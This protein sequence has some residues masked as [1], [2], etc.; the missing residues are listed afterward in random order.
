MESFIR[1]F[2]NEI[3]CLLAPVL[4]IFLTKYIVGEYIMDYVLLSK[5]DTTIELSYI[6]L[7]TSGITNHIFDNPQMG[8]PLVADQNYWPWRNIGIGFYYFIISIFEKD[9]LEIYR[10]FYYSLFPVASLT[11]FICLRYFLNLPNLISLGVS[12]IYAFM[13][14]MYSHNAQHPTVLVGVLC[15]PLVLGSIFY[16]NFKDFRN[17]SFTR[18]IKSKLS[19]IIALIF[20]VSVTLS[21][22][23]AFYSLVILIFLL[24]LQMI[25]SNKDYNRI[26]LILFI[27]GINLLAIFFNIY[28]HLLFK[29]DSHFTFNYMARNFIHT[30]LYSVSIADFFI[31]VKNHIIDSFNFSSQLY[32]QGTLIKDFFNISYLGIFGISSLIFSIFCFFRRAGKENNFWIKIAFIGSLITFLILMFVRGGLMTTFYLYSDLFVLGSNYRITPWILCLSLMSGGLI[33]SHLYKTINQNKFLIKELTKPYIKGISILLFLLIVSFSL[34]DFRG[35]KPVFNK[36]DIP[37]RGSIY[38]EEKAFFDKLEKLITENDMILQ[39]P[40]VCFQETKNILGT[41]Y[42]NT[43][44]YLLIDKKVKF[45]AMS[46]REGTACNINSQLSSM[47]SDTSEMIKY[48]TYFGYT[49]LMIEKRGFIDEGK[50]IKKNILENFGLEP[51]IDSAYLYFDIRGL[52]KEF[53]NIKII[54]KESDP[55]STILINKKSNLIFKEIKKINQ[56]FPSPCMVDNY[57]SMTVNSNESEKITI[58]NTNCE[59][60]K[61]YNN[62]FFYFSDDTIF[63]APGVNMSNGLI[64]LNELFNGDVLSLSIGVPIEPGI[65]K[66]F[67]NDNNGLI[68]DIKSLSLS[69]SHWGRG[70]ISDNKFN[71]TIENKIN[72]TRLKPLTIIIRKNSSEKNITIRSITIRKVLKENK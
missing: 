22:F 48:A 65:Y 64:Y 63:P 27:V 13:P 58:T 42:L 70:F 35:N 21:L 24:I 46:M 14:F 52:K 66:V 62:S 19:I 44:S 57:S 36:K 68:E 10:I 60:T 45:S 56:I 72:A 69:I 18:L 8:A 3:F 29:S 16:I 59:A 71:F 40:F 61:M 7:Y 5:Y 34:I 37:V 15:V 32:S 53:S 33:L 51:L 28:P 38:D 43:W 6:K 9:I 23:S 12:S 50:A 41:T 54:P 2:S 1:K 49:G 26:K 25:I 39:I 31:P 11:M 55:L 17:V 4:A 30:T 67:I 47:S 20:F